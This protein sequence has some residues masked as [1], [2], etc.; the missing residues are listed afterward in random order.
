MNTRN[1][2]TKPYILIFT[3]LFFSIPFFTHA[4]VDGSTVILN[5][6]GDDYREPKIYGAGYIAPSPTVPATNSTPTPTTLNKDEEIAQKVSLDLYLVIMKF[7]VLLA[8]NKI[9]FFFINQLQ[10]HYK[11]Y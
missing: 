9:S 8:K 4:Q 11:I 2:F 5:P 10:A 3:V 1:I 6:Y 7:L